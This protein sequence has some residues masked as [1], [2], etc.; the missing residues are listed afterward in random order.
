MRK[1]LLFS[2]LVLIMS[3]CGCSRSE[4]SIKFNR[5]LRKVAQSYISLT[6]SG[7]SVTAPQLIKYPFFFI[8]RD[9]L[10]MDDELFDKHDWISS[11]ASPKQS[12]STIKHY[13]A[14]PIEEFKSLVYEESYRLDH[15]EVTYT[16]NSGT[17]KETLAPVQYELWVIDLETRTVTAHIKLEPDILPPTVKLKLKH[18]QIDS[19]LGHYKMKK[20]KKEWLESLP[21]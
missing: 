11:K 18:R 13:D 4:E 17:I 16:N 12:L 5:D 10:R 3:I 21:Y 2:T 20:R 9:I 19:D 8:S 15:L 1:I 6:K 7:D 14:I